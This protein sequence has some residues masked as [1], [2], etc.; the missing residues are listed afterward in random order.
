MAKRRSNADRGPF[1]V[2]FLFFSAIAAVLLLPAGVLPSTDTV[3][4]EITNFGS[5]LR[6]RE[7]ASLQPTFQ[8]LETYEHALQDVLDR[9]GDRD[10]LCRYF[11]WKPRPKKQRIPRIFYGTIAGNRGQEEVNEMH[12][13]EVYP[14][15]ERIAALDPK[16]SQIGY[17]REL[18]LDMSD[19]RFSRFR[20]KL[21]HIVIEHPAPGITLFKWTREEE[22]TARKILSRPGGKS[23][24]IETNRLLETWQRTQI[25]KGF[26]NER[27][28]WEMLEDDIVLIA[29]GDEIPLRESLAA[30]KEC[31]NP[32]FEGVQ[33]KLSMGVDAKKACE[34]RAKVLLKSQMFEYYL[35]CPTT[36]PTWWHPDSILAVCLTRG[37]LDT[38][39]VR[40]GSP[41]GVMTEPVAARHVH[42]LGMSNKDVI[43]K[44]LHYAEP[45]QAE[46]DSGTNDETLDEER[47]RACADDAPSIG[48]DNWYMDV[49]PSNSLIRDDN[50]RGYQTEAKNRQGLDRPFALMLERPALRESLYWRGHGERINTFVGKPGGTKSYHG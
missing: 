6:D 49:K 21:R 7:Q 10:G 9:Y 50:S 28:D 13:Q 27:G 5:A 3:V 11:G 8:P 41:D 18:T 34:K 29:D 47:W 14:F 26:M 45:R 30:L 43:N 40:T 19:P 35:D 17:P 46:I 37:E 44:Y 12:F 48:P 15:V 1:L 32:I 16:M 42:N 24:N 20:E 22:R 36:F 23:D 38:E 39:D 33:R 31:E 25:A 2:F 4:N